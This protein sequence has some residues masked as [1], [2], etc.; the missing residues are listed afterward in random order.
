MTGTYLAALLILT[1]PPVVMIMMVRAMVRRLH[2]LTGFPRLL[3]MSRGE[4]GA[5]IVSWSSIKR[6]FAAHADMKEGKVPREIAEQSRGSDRELTA[7]EHG[8]LLESLRNVESQN[9]FLG[10]VTLFVA[11]NIFNLVVRS[12]WTLKPSQIALIFIVM[13]ALFFIVIGRLAAATPLG[14]RHANRVLRVSGNDDDGLR[15]RMQRALVQ[16]FLVK[17]AGFSESIILLAVIAI[18]SLIFVPGLGVFG[19]PLPNDIFT[20]SGWL[21]YHGDSQYWQDH[22]RAVLP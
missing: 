1:G 10:A 15:A 12:N 21:F 9:A 7:R 2:G 13:V 18:I 6:R 22:C 4:Y 5:D 16:H 19:E 3:A 11:T 8:A 20:C 14:Q 17:E